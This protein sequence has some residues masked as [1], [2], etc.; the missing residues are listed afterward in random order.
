MPHMPLCRKLLN[1]LGDVDQ[2]FKRTRLAKY[3]RDASIEF[4]FPVSESES[5]PDI[6]SISSIS[7][8]TSLS[9]LSSA[10][11]DIIPHATLVS[12]T[13]SDLMRFRYSIVQAKI[14]KLR[15]EIQTE[16]NKFQREN[17]TS[18]VFRRNPKI[19]YTPQQTPRFLPLRLRPSPLK[20]VPIL[21]WTLLATVH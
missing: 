17:P 2:S 3:L 20:S 5:E 16:V 6:S 9:S 1:Q 12:L 10:D 15:H 18:R 11:S 8:V 7:S 4:P 21:P 13:P 19:H 14:N